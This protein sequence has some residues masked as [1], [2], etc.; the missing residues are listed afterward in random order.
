MNRNNLIR[1]PQCGSWVDRS[2]GFCPNCGC[3]VRYVNPNAG[4]TSN[5]N[6]YGNTNQSVDP[7][8]ATND[9]FAVTPQGASRGL[10]AIFAIVLGVLGIQYFY[11][12]KNVAGIIVLLV[13]LLSCTMLTVLPVILG[14]AQGI[15]MFTIDN[16]KFY[17]TY[18]N[19]PSTFPLF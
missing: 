13:S 12:G 2:R 7:C 1:C 6:N 16:R 10:T 19:T 5:P 18:V 8:F 15:Y 3:D 9:P 17:D 14:I 11:T 4:P